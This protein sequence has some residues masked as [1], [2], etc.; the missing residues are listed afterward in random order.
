MCMHNLPTKVQHVV[1]IWPQRLLFDNCDQE[2]L[3]WA[4]R[5]YGLNPQLQT[6]AEHEALDRF[7]FLTSMLKNKLYKIM[8]V[9]KSEQSGAREGKNLTSKTLPIPD[10]RHGAVSNRE[11]CADSHPTA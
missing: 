2:A 4:S 9:K 11:L 8:T 7:I 1:E 6:D 3:T 5:T 10:S